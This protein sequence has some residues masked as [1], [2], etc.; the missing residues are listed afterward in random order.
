MNTYSLV[1]FDLDGTLLDP[2][3]GVR[4]SL[5]YTLAVMGCRMPP[6]DKWA[7]F[8]GPPI[9]MSLKK[10][11]PELTDEQLGQAVTTFRE[12]YK[13]VTLLKARVYDGVLPML[14]RLKE[15][16]KVAVATYKRH[17]YALT[18]TDY[19]KISRY[20]THVQGSDSIKF[21]TKSAIVDRC[22]LLLDGKDKRE[23]VLVGDTEHDLNGAAQ[24]GIDFISVTY[25]YGFKKGTMAPDSS[26]NIAMVD[27]VTELEHLLLGKL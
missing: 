3:E 23:A 21:P 24:S 25:G 19:C 7:T 27:T 16:K 11:Y 15:K 8:I 5:E 4:A 12:H 18:L 1:I 10:A 6:E 9:E 13:D 14:Q 17:D 26:M 22:L 2:F 20:C